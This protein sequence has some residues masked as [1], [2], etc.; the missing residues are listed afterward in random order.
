MEKGKHLNALMQ[1]FDF[2][3][4]ELAANQVGA[5][6]PSQHRKVWNQ[7]RK[8]HYELETLTLIMIVFLS[9]I[10]SCGLFAETSEEDKNA[11]LCLI[12]FILCLIAVFPASFLYDV[13]RFWQARRENKV[14]A[15]DLLLHKQSWPHTSEEKMLQFTRSQML[16][17]QANMGYRAYCTPHSDRVLSIE[18]VEV[19]QQ[20]QQK[21]SDERRHQ[22][23]LTRLLQQAFEFSVNELA[24]NERGEFSPAQCEN[25]VKKFGTGASIEQICAVSGAIRLAV[26]DNIPCVYIGEQQFSLT[27]Q[28]L[29]TLKTGDFYRFY[30]SS[31]SKTILSLKRFKE[32]KQLYFEE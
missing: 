25:L 4:E 19:R 7:F 5:L 32:E 8:R 12:L 30:Y 15:V 23:R 11:I 6:L 21:E 9:C 26:E 16:A 22:K 18:V 1:A 17:L 13:Y 2:T 14:I 3:P 28:Q 31:H 29:H 24:A 10:S 27:T 20:K